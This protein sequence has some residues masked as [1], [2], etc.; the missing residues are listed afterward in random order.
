MASTG[1]LSPIVIG[2]FPILTNTLPNN[3]GIYLINGSL[4][5]KVSNGFAHF[6]INFFSLLNFF[7]PSTSIN[8]IPAF[9][10]Y[11]QW[12]ADPIITIFILGYGAFGNL[13][14]PVNLLSFS[15]S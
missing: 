7:N 14:D 12:T 5:T 10:A 9:F 6:L 3:L 1:S 15:G 13:I 2:N 4:A 8:G 11:S